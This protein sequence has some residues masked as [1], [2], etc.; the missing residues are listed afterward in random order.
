MKILI[1]YLFSTFG[2]IP[3]ATAMT[4][5]DAQNKPLHELYKDDFLIGNIIAGGLHPEDPPFRED[6]GELEILAREFNCL[7]SENNM[8]TMFVQPKEGVF[9]FKGPDAAIDFA[10]ANGMDYVGHALV[11]HAMVPDWIFKHK[12]GTEVN[13]EV[14]IERM[15]TH[16]NTVVGR[17][18]GR[19]KYWDVVNEAID[20]KWMKDPETGKKEQVAFLRD[21]P[22]LRIIGKDYIELAY[23][24]TH[25]ADPDA[26]LLYNDYSMFDEPKA[27]FAAG[28]V[29]HLK[30]KGIPMHGVGFQGHWHLKYPKLEDVQRSIDLMAGIGVKV[31]ISELDVGI[32]PLLDDYQGADVDKKIELNPALNPYVD[33]VPERVLKQQARRYREI[34]ELFLRNSDA[35]ERVSF[36]GTLDQYSWINDWPV[37]G[38]TAAPLLFGRDYQAKP[39]YHALRE[40]KQ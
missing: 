2:L 30:S 32:L 40:L 8:K 9:D 35:I 18:K 5:V 3:F 21:T 31:S 29:L 23:R 16:I 25:E 4:D 36:W 37:K 17:Y 38:R 26:L 15:R 22:W 19:I 13:R 14:L 20:T 12:D 10:E 39:A 33:G 24:M 28:L 7:T 27:R 1:I 11:W 6:A 34:F